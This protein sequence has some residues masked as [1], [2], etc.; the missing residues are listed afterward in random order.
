MFWIILSTRLESHLCP[1]SLP[2]TSPAERRLPE[3]RNLPTSAVFPAHGRVLGGWDGSVAGM[4]N[5]L[6]QDQLKKK[7]PPDEPSQLN[8]K[9]SQH[10]LTHSSQV[11][12]M[13]IVPQTGAGG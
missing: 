5:G 8:R 9:L 6:N 12:T 1:L 13:G 11:P 7:I 4:T 3:G 2:L 10:L